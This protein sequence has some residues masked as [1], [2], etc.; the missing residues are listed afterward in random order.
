MAIGN[1]LLT[2]VSHELLQS[3]PNL[4]HIEVRGPVPLA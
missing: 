4:V 3:A 2:P 1:D